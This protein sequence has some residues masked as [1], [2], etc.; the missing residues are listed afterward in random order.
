M[1]QKATQ[2]GAINLAQGFPNFDGPEQIKDAACRAI[3]DGY[4]QYA[5]APGILPLREALARHQLQKS[6][7]SFDPGSEITV[8]SGA[9][10]ALF[11]S[12]A[13]TLQPGDELLCFEP[14]YD[15]YPAAVLAAGAT[16]KTI[17][18]RGG[19]WSFDLEELRAAITGR[20]K[21]LLI[22]TPNNP[23]GKVFSREE[24]LGIAKIVADHDLK[25]VTDEVYEELVY[26][27]VHTHFATLP[28]M[29]ERTITI[30]ST[31]KTFSMT[32]WKVGYAFAPEALMQ[33][34]RNL[35]QFTVFCSSTPLQWGMVAA[36]ELPASYYEEFRREYL[37]RRDT[38]AAFLSECG[39]VFEK[40]SGSYF[41]VADYS[42]HSRLPS[43]E[44]AHRLCEEVGV[45]SIPIGAFYQDTQ[46]PLP[47][48]RFAFCKDLATLEKAG[49]RLRARGD[50]LLT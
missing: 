24:L 19:D 18:L 35:H 49:Q 41:I 4:N 8:F 47:Y 11:C 28:G 40:P 10:E 15:S 38:A 27:G 13:A 14:F 3:R 46:T 50:R 43:F 17:P 29:R 32:G 33:P 1:S 16:M 36:F 42:R 9:T 25:V 23:T 44:F 21:V 26:A 2:L 5:P 20:S 22:N 48:V 39:F 37:M 7:L 31:S 6:G 30:S 34:I 45:A 12:L